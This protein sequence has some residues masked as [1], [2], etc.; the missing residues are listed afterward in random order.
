M[1]KK[2]KNIEDIDADYLDMML[3]NFNYSITHGL[4]N[5]YIGYVIIDDNNIKEYLVLKENWV[6]TLNILIE[7]A[8]ELEEYEYAN[9]F[10]KIKESL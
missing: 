7:A 1:R 2:E 3:Y 10:K 4:D 5:V 6:K 9:D 8:V